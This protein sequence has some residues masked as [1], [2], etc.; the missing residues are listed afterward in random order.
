MDNSERAYVGTLDD[1]VARY[2][3]NGKMRSYTLDSYIKNNNDP[4]LNRSLLNSFNN[5]LQ[6]NALFGRNLLINDGYILNHPAS[7]M[8]LL[9][10]ECSPLSTLIKKGHVQILRRELD[11]EETVQKMVLEKNTSFTML[12]KMNDWPSFRQE[13]RNISNINGAL[14][15][16]PKV[17]ISQGLEKL[18]Y[19]YF[20]SPDKFASNLIS[21]EEIINFEKIYKEIKVQEKKAPRDTWE[22]AA[23]KFFGK[24]KVKLYEI[25]HIANSYYHFNFA[26]CLSSETNLGIAVETIPTAGTEHL[27]EKSLISFSHQDEIDDIKNF[28]GK[29]ADRLYFPAADTLLEGDKLCQLYEGKTGSAGEAKLIFLKS[30]GD[31]KKGN[32]NQTKFD[33]DVQ[34]YSEALKELFEPRP[35]VG[36]KGFDLIIEEIKKDPSKALDIKQMALKLVINNGVKTILS[37]LYPPIPPR[38]P[39]L[40]NA[41]NR[42]SL[43]KG[44]IVSA[45]IDK[46]LAI[47][48]TT[49]LNKFG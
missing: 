38:H 42:N 11:L 49:G 5:V 27:L 33:N 18:F 2:P 4:L 30:L 6:F 28:F 37:Y 23:Q 48:H 35:E 12:T 47:K 1:V 39:F 43:L 13:L 22:I 16:W 32:V 24:N 10:P 14:K 26:M 45:P 44:V 9:N 41:E 36:K 7:K 31:F 21:S 20:N 17:D 15:S 8:A 3:W 40:V 46:E 25:M 29:Y 19:E 34:S